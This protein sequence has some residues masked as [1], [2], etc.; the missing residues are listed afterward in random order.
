MDPLSIAALIIIA[1]GS[2]NKIN[3][4]VGSWCVHAHWVY[5]EEYYYFENGVMV[6]Y[7]D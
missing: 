3:R 4:T 7:Q 2:P 1:L 6:S 5:K